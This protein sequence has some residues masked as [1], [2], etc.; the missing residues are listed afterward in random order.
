MQEIPIYAADTFEME[1][2]ARADRPQEIPQLLLESDR[3]VFTP[4]LGSAVD[5]ARLAIERIAANSILQAL[6]GQ[7][8]DH[9]VNRPG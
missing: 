7:V 4:H 5:D 8:P 3:T 1:D 6:R 9:T 2:W